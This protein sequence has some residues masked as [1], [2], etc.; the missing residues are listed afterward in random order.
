MAAIAITLVDVV[1]FVPICLH[2]PATSGGFFREFGLVIAVATL[3]S[4]FV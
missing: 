3:M 1:V 2:A 4:L